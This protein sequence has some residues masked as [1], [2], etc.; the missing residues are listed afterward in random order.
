MSNPST[1]TFRLSYYKILNTEKIELNWGDCGSSASSPY[2]TQDI[3]I[4][5]PGDY[6]S[7]TDSDGFIDRKS[8]RLNSSHI[9][10]SRMPSSA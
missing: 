3:S 5:N 1:T 10:E 8:T 7:Y 6:T 9:E 4:T 2:K